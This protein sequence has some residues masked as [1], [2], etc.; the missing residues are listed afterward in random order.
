[1][2]DNIGSKIKSLAKIV[3]WA[4]IIITVIAGIVLLA[5]GG[6]VSSPI[7]LVLVIA[8]PI[9][10]WIGSF[11]VYGFGELIEKTSEIAENT[12]PKGATP[13]S[14][15]EVAEGVENEDKKAL[16]KKWREQGLIT[17]EEY[18]QK[19]NRL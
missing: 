1:M 3:C 13:I 7:G 4:G 11:F 5:S 12:K 19:M 18:Q 2:F 8:G 17:E 16:L 6:D 15:Q 9:S 10:S 14:S